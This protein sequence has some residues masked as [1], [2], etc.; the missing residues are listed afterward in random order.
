MPNSSVVPVGVASIPSVSKEGTGSAASTQPASSTDDTLDELVELL[1]SVLDQLA[2]TQNVDPPKQHPAL[3]VHAQFSQR[4]KFSFARTPDIDVQSPAP[5]STD[6][7]EPIGE[8]SEA[9]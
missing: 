9:E 2:E 7:N 3:R 4:L 5:P 1:K 8:A 6:G